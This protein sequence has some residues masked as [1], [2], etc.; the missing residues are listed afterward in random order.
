MKGLRTRK[1]SQN[2]ELSPPE[3]LCGLGGGCRTKLTPT[4]DNWGCNRSKQR[5]VW[6]TRDVSAGGFSIVMYTEGRPRP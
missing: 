4:I 2:S 1:L 5:G 6:I 3:T